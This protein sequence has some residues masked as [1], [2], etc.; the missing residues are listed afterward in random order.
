MS[1]AIKRNF[2]I[3]EAQRWIGVTE[4]NGDNTGQVVQLFQK[5][6]DNKAIREPW[7]LA[8]VM[9]CIKHIDNMCLRAKMKE[10]KNSNLELTEHCM[11]LW[12]SSVKN[13]VTKPMPGDLII[14]QRYVNG[15]PTSAGH[16]GIIEQV[17]PN[18]HFVTI[19]G[20]TSPTADVI[21]RDGDGVYRKTRTPQGDGT[22]KVVGYLRVWID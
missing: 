5:A 15:K 20:N 13:R 22:M 2:L 1:A 17:L 10:H 7:C 11:T 18:G 19:E 6:V 4:I 8:Y 12:N 16:V 21:E 3:T 14:W 9:F